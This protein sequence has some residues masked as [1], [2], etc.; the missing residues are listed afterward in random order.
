[1]LK[2]SSSEYFTVAISEIT[3]MG[4]LY[5]WFTAHDFY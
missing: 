1:M 5:L 2:I 4:F 3:A